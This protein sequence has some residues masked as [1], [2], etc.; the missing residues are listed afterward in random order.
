MAKRKKIGIYFRKSLAGWTGGLYYNLNLISA[1]NHLEDSQKP[2]LII[3]ANDEFYK[4]A[5]QTG[6]PYLYR[7]T[8][9]ERLNIKPDYT[10]IERIVNKIGIKL[11]KKQIIDKRLT[12]KDLHF[13][14]PILNLTSDLYEENTF[15]N[16]KFYAG[17]PKLYWI[18]DFQE[19]YLPQ[20]FS[21]EEILGRKATQRTMSEQNITIVFS[22]EDA[23]KDFY[24]FYPDT[25]AITKL[26]RFSVTHPDYSGIDIKALQVKFNID[27]PYFFSPNQFWAHKN[28][29]VIIEAARI[30]KEKGITSFMIAF[31]GKED[32]YRNPGYLDS[33]KNKVGEY[34]LENHIRFLGF[35]DRAEQLKLM[36]MAI[37]VIQPSLFEGWSTVIEDAKAM[38]QLVMASNLN[39]HHE[40][41]TQNALFFNPLDAHDLADKIE[42]V[43]SGG[44]SNKTQIDYS[45]NIIKFAKDFINII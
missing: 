23:R 22:S 41:L 36:S 15:K 37:A 26:L 13:I 5:Q 32:D 31:S 3:F 20:F 45:Q 19:H 16:K 7:S 40:Q 21:K 14:F 17:I 27:N 28:H 2:L 29:N 24:K 4:L 18:P 8:E 9:I 35:L 1:L 12:Q 43:I 34:Q 39:V 33:L 10:V 42:L 6:Y 38:N 25:K 11:F 30:L 44:F